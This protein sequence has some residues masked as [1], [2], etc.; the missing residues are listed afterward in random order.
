MSI[1]ERVAKL[2][3]AIEFILNRL[4]RMMDFEFH[5]LYLLIGGLAAIAFFVVK[6]KWGEDED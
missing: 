6:K 3:A 2:E 5:M 1:E 4:D